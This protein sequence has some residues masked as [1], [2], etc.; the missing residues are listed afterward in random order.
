MERAYAQALWR[1]ILSGEKPAHAIAAL[2]RLLT[3]QGRTA[4]MPKIGHA[5][6]RLALRERGQHTMRL[7]VAREKDTARARK[8]AQEFLKG[9]V[10]METVLDESV[11]GGWRLEGNDLLIDN[12][13]K[14]HLTELYRRIV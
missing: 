11:V 12:T 9:D 2:H 1:K 6:E 14:R 10:H 13:H 4:L 3:T 5:F 8:H 7:T